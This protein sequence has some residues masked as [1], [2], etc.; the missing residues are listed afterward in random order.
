MTRFWW[1]K[2][3]SASAAVPA[4]WGCP[5]SAQVARRPLRRLAGA[6]PTGAE[7]GYERSGGAAVGPDAG[8]EAGGGDAATTTAGSSASVTVTG[9]GRVTSGSSAAAIAFP[10]S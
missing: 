10:F 8:T 7:A 1:G 6:V 5:L 3:E 2:T 4:P 9:S